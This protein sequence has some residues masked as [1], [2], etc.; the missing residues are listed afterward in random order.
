MNL[1]GGHLLFGWHISWFSGLCVEEVIYLAFDLLSVPLLSVREGGR[2]VSRGER[3]RFKPFVLR[4]AA[5]GLGFL[6]IPFS[7]YTFIILCNC[8][9]ECENSFAQVNLFVLY[10]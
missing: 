5:Q 6:C 8:F 2:E 7:F 1:L 9:Y 10:Q 3:S 4:W